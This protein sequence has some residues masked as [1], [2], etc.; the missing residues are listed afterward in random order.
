M[1]LVT[2]NFLAVHGAT[3]H[4]LS[5][6]VAVSGN[7][8]VTAPGTY[9]WVAT[10]SGD[11]NNM[12]VVSACGSE[13]VLV[14]AQTLTGHAY[15]LKADAA[16]LGLLNL[17]VPPLAD[18]GAV[19]TTASST[20]STPC[21]ATLSGVVSA[22]VI[23]ANVTTT[24][25]PAQSAASASIADATVE[26]P[27]LPVIS[28]ATIQSTSATTC[29]SSAGATTIAFLQIGNNVIISKPTPVAPNTTI[30][31]GILKVVLNEQLPFSTPDKG[32][33]VNA[34]HVTVNGAPLATANVVLA[35]SESDIGNCP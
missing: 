33:T 7:V 14:T 20:T 6:A 21:V 17:H 16:V 9:Q 23:C 19:S 31:L 30:N 13:P 3:V 10:Y 35:S 18:T 8:P 5:G 2:E 34:V 26:L 32:L 29:A 22:H 1:A 28:L 15:G 25:A 11:T 27:G 12:G 4:T 24:Q